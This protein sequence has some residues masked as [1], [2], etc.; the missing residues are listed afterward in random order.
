MATI[1]L[2]LLLFF[3]GANLYQPLTKIYQKHNGRPNYQLAYKEINQNYNDRKHGLFLQF[4]RTYYLQDL[5]EAN[6]INLGTH[7]EYRL[8]DLLEQANTYKSGWISWAW[9]KRGHVSSEIR[10]YADENFEKIHGTGVDETGVE[11]Y[12]FDLSK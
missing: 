12:Y 11:V 6:I 8:K 1:V 4:P 7:A 3:I 9:Y 10:E 5:H 2:L